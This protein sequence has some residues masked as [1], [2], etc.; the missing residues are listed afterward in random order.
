MKSLLKAIFAQIKTVP[1]IKWIDEDFGQID[2]YDDRPPV[3]FPCALVSIDQ[4]SDPLGGDE[5]DQTNTI[6]VR[7]AHSRLGDR[8]G[9]APEAAMDATLKKLDDVEAV[10][11]TLTGFEVQG[12]TGTLYLVS[13]NSE[14]RADGI[15]VKALV[16]RET[17]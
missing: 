13:A 2:Q 11:T 15:A 4:L 17:H 16:F 5:Y 6:T 7:V 12:V 3:Q 8:S 14:R 10:I 9:M 1:A